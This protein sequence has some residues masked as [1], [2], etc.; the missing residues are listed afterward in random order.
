MSDGNVAADL[1]L[2]AGG[3]NLSGW[4]KVRVTRGIERLPGDFDIEMTELSPFDPDHV[5]VRPGDPCQ[6]LLG[7]DLVITGYVDRVRPAIGHQRHSIQ[8]TGRGKCQ[9]LVDCAAIWPGG[10]ISGTSVLDIAQKLAAPYGVTVSSDVT[11][12]P[13]IP[14]VNLMLGETPFEIIERN[15]RYCALLA[16][17][18]PDGNLVLTRVG[19]EY[20]G[21]GLVE[22][23]NIQE[24]ST[25]FSM[26]QR[27]SEYVAFMQGVETLQDLGGGG[28]QVLTV[29]DPN[30]PRL[31]RRIL[32]AETVGGPIDWKDFLNLRAQWEAARRAG[33][34]LTV[35]IATDS[36]RDGQGALWT[37]NT[38]VPVSSPS[39]KLR[40]DTDLLL[41]QVTY[42]FSEQGT[43]ADLVLMPPGAF[44]P[45]PQAPV[46][47]PLDTPANP[48]K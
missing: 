41:G 6:I 5:T 10:Q 18:Q 46:G 48:G 11:G 17:D 33:R 30:V 42:T 44:S 15:A 36:W 14:Q 26:D 20:A 45:Q 31:R 43:R 24:G 23:I 4:T 35:N 1:T 12:V 32:V 38:L 39:L 34:S 22:G 28:N 47:A 2:V 9:D 21:S 27:F 13:P 37:P 40:A 25:L 8:V 7:A 16:Y 19:S 29:K 3:R